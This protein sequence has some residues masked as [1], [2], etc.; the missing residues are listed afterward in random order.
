MT[1]EEVLQVINTIR[2]NLIF[3]KFKLNCV[4]IFLFLNIENHN[5][6]SEKSIIYKSFQK[7]YDDTYK[8]KR[9]EAEP[10]EV[11]KAPVTYNHNIGFYKF[12]EGRDLNDVQRPIKKC[13]ET[14][15]A[16]FMIKTG[17]QFL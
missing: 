1:W 14:K 9:K 7:Y 16:E 12:E 13:N 11:F 2:G 15:F 4:F 8:H 6:K 17:K 5:G 3:E 10:N